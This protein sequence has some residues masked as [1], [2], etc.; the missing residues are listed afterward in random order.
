MTVP[1]ARSAALV[2]AFLVT[3]A[4]GAPALAA[5]DPYRPSQWGLERIA[6]P[7]AWGVDRGEGQVIAIVDS[8]VDL[9]HPDLVD[10]FVRDAAGNILGR[11]YIDDDTIPQDRNGHGTMVAGIAAATADNGV[12]IAGV[13][14]GAE[15]LPVRVLDAH[16]RGSAAD[17]DAAIRWAVDNGATVVNLSL[18]SVA[19]LPGTI[20]SQAPEAAVRYAWERGVVVVAAAG[21]SGSGFTDYSESS[22]VLLV[23]ATDHDDEPASFSDSG[24]D[25][26]VMAPGVGIISTWCD[27]TPAGCDPENGYGQADGTSFAAPSVAGAVAVLRAAGRTPEES[28]EHL[29]RTAVDLGPAGPDAR[30]GHGRIDLAAAVTGTPN[31]EETP[32][33]GVTEAGST[34]SEQPGPAPTVSASTVPAP[35]DASTG[36]T[37]AP[38]DSPA[39]T[40][41]SA[42]PTS[43]K[44]PGEDITPLATP[45]EVS[46]LAAGDGRS[47]DDLLR[48]LASVLVAGSTVTWIRARRSSPSG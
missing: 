24:R 3:V 37:G 42:S 14:P 22:P 7:A 19:P 41:P 25:D 38:P 11:D 31:E 47:G 18:E 43:T 21:N 27:P 9:G 39:P 46:A 13:A 2:A 12:G 17:V 32:R 35:T 28:L 29:R 36:A 5:D 8:G 10:R 48:F 44:P 1:A 20:V 30:H 45:P 33:G 4:S 15:L 6:A 40:A 23:G 26:A 16:G 34:T